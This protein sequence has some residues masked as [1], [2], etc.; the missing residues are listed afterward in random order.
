MYIYCIIICLEVF[1]MTYEEFCKRIEEELSTGGTTRFIVSNVTLSSLLSNE[2]K[3]TVRHR[4]IY[5]NLE[6]EEKLYELMA[7]GDPTLLD[8]ITHLTLSDETPN[9][10]FINNYGSK[11]HASEHFLARWSMGM[12]TPD[13]RT[14]T[15]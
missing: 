5:L 12:E 2:T 7:V 4:S 3:I 14:V 9:N 8:G 15:L 1:S 10:W 11:Y 13:L 6:S